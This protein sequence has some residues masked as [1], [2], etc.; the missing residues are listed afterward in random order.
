MK[1]LLLLTLSLTAQASAFGVRDPGV[2]YFSLCGRYDP[3]SRSLTIRGAE[4]VEIA[5]GTSAPLED[6]TYCFRGASF[7]RLE[8]EGIWLLRADSHHLVMRQLSYPVLVCA[9]LEKDGFHTSWNQE[10]LSFRGELPARA[11]EFGWCADGKNFPEQTK[12][13]W[14]FRGARFRE[15]PDPYKRSGMSIGNQ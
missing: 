14:L 5:E 10:K 1:I 12:D 9:V 7:R 13:G 2:R 11:K 4:K 3:P 6:G 15:M 8:S